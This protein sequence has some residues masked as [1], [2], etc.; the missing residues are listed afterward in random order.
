MA[1]LGLLFP[2]KDRDDDLL[3][4]DAHDRAALVED[5]LGDVELVRAADNPDLEEREL[6]RPQHPQS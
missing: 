6:Q 4:L 5:G 2:L 1:G 3:A